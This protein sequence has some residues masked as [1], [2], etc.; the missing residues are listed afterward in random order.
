V[1]SIATDAAS[2]IVER[3]IGA[4]ADAKAVTDAVEKSMKD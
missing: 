1:K 3:L 2:E 4:K